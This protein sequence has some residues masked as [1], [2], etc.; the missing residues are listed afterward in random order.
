MG[1]I[2][3]VISP[4]ALVVQNIL[5]SANAVGVLESLNKPY[6]SMFV[7]ADFHRDSLYNTALFVNF[8]KAGFGFARHYQTPG[9]DIS[10][11]MVYTTSPL[12]H[13]H[14]FSVYLKQGEIDEA[15]RAA[16]IESLQQYIPLGDTNVIIM[17]NLGFTS[18]K[19]AGYRAL[20]TWTKKEFFDPL[21]EWE[22]NSPV[23]AQNYSYST[24]LVHRKGKDT[25]GLANRFN[26]I[27]HSGSLKDNYVVGSYTNFGNDGID[28]RKTSLL[29]PKNKAITEGN[30]WSL[31]ATGL[32]LPVYADFV[33][34]LPSDIYS[35]NGELH[36]G[37]TENKDNI[38]I[39]LPSKGVITVTNYLGQIIHRIKSEGG[40]ENF[41]K[42]NLKQGVYF[43]QIT[44]HLHN[45][46]ITKYH[47]FLIAQ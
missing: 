29:E 41:S 45:G 11:Y 14:I 24:S 42:N 40:V 28:R 44:R 36:T 22:A 43:I 38:S 23:H 1:S 17:G 18:S 20:T 16:E 12:E 33:F 26:L 47:R 3:N 6:G 9:K 27:L 39:L 34:N 5:D 15:T 10:H 13:I 31:I 32:H 7:F 2:W 46:P 30:V 4:A 8:D 19:E 37:V 35:F 21:G 25:L